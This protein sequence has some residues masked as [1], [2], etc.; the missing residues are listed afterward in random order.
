MK[1]KGRGLIH[2]I[3]FYTLADILP[4]LSNE[5]YQA[6]IFT[7]RDRQLDVLSEAHRQGQTLRLKFFFK[8]TQISTTNGNR[9][10]NYPSFG[11]YMHHYTKAV[12]HFIEV[13]KISRCKTRYSPHENN[14][15]KGYFFF[16]SK[17]YIT[18]SSTRYRLQTKNCERAIQYLLS[19]LKLREKLLRSNIN[20]LIILFTFR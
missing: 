3:T 5:C 13:N 15:K 1:E 7:N 17:R 19:Y 4:T 10:R 16:E 6:D 20:R 8:Q 9:N 14:D 12:I 2:H 18:L 11:I